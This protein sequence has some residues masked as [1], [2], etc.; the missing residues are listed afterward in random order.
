MGDVVFYNNDTKAIVYKNKSNAEYHINFIDNSSMNIEYIY[1]NKVLF[2][3][4]DKLLDCNNLQSF[5]RIMKNKNYQFENGKL[6]AKSK[7][8]S[9]PKI[10]QLK[11]DSYYLNNFITF[12]IETKNEI[13][14]LYPMQSLILMAK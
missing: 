6:V 10:K 12:D 9:L 5:I 3:F 13:M 14:K 1:N 11:K 4:T 8:H 7:L 2:K